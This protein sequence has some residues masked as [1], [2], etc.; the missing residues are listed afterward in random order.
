MAILQNQGTV[1]YTPA[2]G[3]RT[4][5]ISNTTNT[6]VEISYSLS[7]SHAAYPVTYTAGAE[8]LYT[9][10]LRNTG[11]G[12]YFLPEIVSD[13]GGGKL[14]YVTDSAVA[15]LDDGTN[16]VPLVAT[17]EI[18]GGTATFRFG[19]AT[20]PGGTQIL[21]LYRATVGIPGGDIVSTVTGS[22]H[23]GSA[24]GTVDTATDSATITETP[25]TVVKS[26]PE[27][28]EVGETI[29][30]RFTLT[31]NSAGTI[32]FDNLSDQLPA[33]F[34]FT[35]VTLTVAGTAVALTE[36]TDY[37]VSTGNLFTLS[38]VIPPSI[39]EGGTAILTLTGVVTA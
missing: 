12:T 34:S 13:L 36:G 33:N 29:S 37:T 27:S 28:A 22:G 17:A 38:P 19:D 14:N 16:L 7:V 31:N 15:Y 9:T 11:S 35:G 8:I 3:A 10:L 18:A 25:L 4:T 23:E 1:V 32:A 2:G 39:P 20:L 5:V 6:E 24:T 30:Y 26:A 21:L